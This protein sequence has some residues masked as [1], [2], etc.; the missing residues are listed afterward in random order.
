MTA[1]LNPDRTTST[2]TRSTLARAALLLLVGSGL[3][4]GDAG[5]IA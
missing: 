4:V 3:A 5:L 1:P 2:I